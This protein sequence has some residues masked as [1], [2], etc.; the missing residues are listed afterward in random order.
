MKEL[1]K[2]CNSCYQLQNGE[3][4][5]TSNDKWTGCAYKITIT[6][7][8]NQEIIKKESYKVV[9]NDVYNSLEVYFT[10]KPNKNII[11]GLKM[12][13][14]RW[15]P[16]KYC[17][18]GFAT[19]EEITKAIEEPMTIDNK[20]KN[21]KDEVK[22]EYGVQVG[23][24]FSYSFGYDATYYEFYQVRKI[25]SKKMVIVSKIKPE[26]RHYEAENQNAWSWTLCNDG[27]IYNDD[28]MFPEEINIKKIVKLSKWSSE[29]LP[30][31]KVGYN[32][33]YTAHLMTKGL[34][35]ISEDDYH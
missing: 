1:N 8:Q 28:D 18:Y 2:M 15:N 29:P 31:I 17:W 22:N 12:L 10:S 34:H 33:Y 9:K 7:A 25:I 11:D 30:Q 24:V 14:M 35:K 23:D 4:N 26:Q 20:P 19:V 3:C 16:K 27:T 6:N 13:K 5:G 21:S 32:N